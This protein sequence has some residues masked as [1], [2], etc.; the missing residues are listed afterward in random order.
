MKAS[1]M[2]LFKKVSLFGFTTNVQPLDIEESA[3]FMLLF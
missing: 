2:A 3:L 1:W